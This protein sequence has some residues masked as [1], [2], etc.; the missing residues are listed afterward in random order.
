MDTLRRAR[1]HL[2][3]L[4]DRIESREVAIELGRKLGIES[5]R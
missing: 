3:N 4:I 5:N 1:L 2:R